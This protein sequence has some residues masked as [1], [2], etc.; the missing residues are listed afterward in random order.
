MTAE[1]LEFDASTLRP[2]P[3][4]SLVPVV[5]DAAQVE[6][7][8]GTDPVFGTVRWRTLICGD[9]TGPGDMVLGVAEFGPGDRLEP[10]RHA[11]SE[12]YFGL[13]GEGT[14]TIEGAAHRIAP[15][16]A[17]YIPGEAEHGVE[18]GAFGLSFA[19]GF[20][21]GRFAEVDYRF[22]AAAQ[23]AGE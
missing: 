14:V 6:L 9:R 20:P 22:T 11:P 16:V 17:I 15:G 21:R 19:Y 7:E 8:G 5:V 3:P 23:A 2:A 10:H 4:R 12:F 13:S 18:A 1:P